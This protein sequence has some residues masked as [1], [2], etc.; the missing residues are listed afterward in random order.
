MEWNPGSQRWDPGAFYPVYQFANLG[1]K[2]RTKN[3]YLE[4]RI[5]WGKV[6]KMAAFA[7][8]V[9]ELPGYRRPNG[10]IGRGNLG[11]EN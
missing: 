6:D 3:V 5:F 11:L 9:H 7:H 1:G 2:T 4:M 10:W 8:F